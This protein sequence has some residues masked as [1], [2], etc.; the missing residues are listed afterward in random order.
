[1]RYYDEMMMK[2]LWNCFKMLARM[3]GCWDPQFEPSVEDIVDY[4][5]HDMAIF[6]VRFLWRDRIRGGGGGISLFSQAHGRWRSRLGQPAQAAHPN[7]W[8]MRSLSPCLSLNYGTFHEGQG[9]F[10]IVTSPNPQKRIQPTNEVINRKVM[11]KLGWR[12][13]QN[14]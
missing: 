4:Q 11:M 5:W 12:L 13:L 9:K 10:F 14:V 3:K 7:I 8:S 2:L 1:M 6:S